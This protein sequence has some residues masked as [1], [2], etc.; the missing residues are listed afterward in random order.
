MDALKPLLTTLGKLQIGNQNIAYWL[1]RLGGRALSQKMTVTAEVMGSH[2]HQLNCIFKFRLTGNG[3]FG[4]PSH[5]QIVIFFMTK[6]LWL[7]LSK[8]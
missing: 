3:H 4:K 5:F 2:G 6:V 7:I 1:S 8:R